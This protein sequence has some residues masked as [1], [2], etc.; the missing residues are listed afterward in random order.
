MSSSHSHIAC[1]YGEHIFAILVGGHLI[2]RRMQCI[3]FS[4][5]L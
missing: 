2:V 3:W 5:H 4:Y 1:C